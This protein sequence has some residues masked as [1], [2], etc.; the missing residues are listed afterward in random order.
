M[1]GAMRCSCL[2]HSVAIT[3][4]P[5]EVSTIR[6]SRVHW[7]MTK[8]DVSRRHLF[9]K[10][11]EMDHLLMNGRGYHFFEYATFTVD[12]SAVDWSNHNIAPYTILL[13]LRAAIS[14]NPIQPPSPES[15]T[16]PTPP[17]EPY[18]LP[19]HPHAYPPPSPAFPSP[20]S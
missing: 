9:G 1:N 8:R 5:S 18:P 4:H 20:T 17:P 14:F 2:Y 10:T 19:L 15:S 7:P 3:L 16:H 13:L 12:H 11:A 6:Q